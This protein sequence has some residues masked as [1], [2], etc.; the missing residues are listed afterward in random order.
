MRLYDHD[1]NVTTWERLQ[2]AYGPGIGVA[3]AGI[4]PHYELVELREQ[5]GDNNARVQV[6]DENGTPIPGLLVVYSWA[7]GPEDLSQPAA[8]VFKTILAPHVEKDVTDGDG[9][10]TFTWGKGSFYT[11][12]AVGAHSVWVL[13]DKYPSD[14]FTGAGF[15]AWTQ[16][17]GL[18]NLTFQF[19]PDGQT[20][21]PEPEPEP[22]DTTMVGLLREIR[23]ELRVLRVH[24]GAV[25]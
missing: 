23:D 7:G 8:R 17:Q 21:E 25:R 13:S 2:A 9:R 4:G 22:G 15:I 5:L 14:G 6:L 18:T 11:P 12:P 10:V 1:G 3:A 24:L 20:P 19:N 16:Y